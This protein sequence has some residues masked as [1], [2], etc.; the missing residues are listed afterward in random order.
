MLHALHGS[1]SRGENQK[2]VSD[3]FGEMEIYIHQMKALST[4]KSTVIHECANLYYKQLKS[5]HKVRSN[6]GKILVFAL[7]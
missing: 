5:V 7:L 4:G 6:Y 3:I 2:G 1:L